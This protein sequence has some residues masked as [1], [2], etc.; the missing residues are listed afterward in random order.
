MISRDQLFGSFV[1]EFREVPTAIGVGRVQNLNEDELSEFYA[2]QFTTKGELSE[3][4]QRQRR[5]RLVAMCLVDDDGKRIL[6]QAGDITRLGPSVDGAVI[7]TLF[8][9]ALEHCGMQKLE[10]ESETL[11]KN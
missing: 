5:R 1:R 7:S 9:A 2:G 8:L 4:Y 6:D 11:E 3:T 10:E